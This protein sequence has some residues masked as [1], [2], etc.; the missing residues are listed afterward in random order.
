MLN[1]LGLFAGIGGLELGLERSGLCTS[2]C[3]VEKDEYCQKVLAGRFPEVPIWDDVSTFDGRPWK[4][5]IDIISGGFPC[6]DISVAGRGEG[7][8]GSRSG[9]WAEFWRIIGEI[10]PIF[11]IIENVPMLT[12]RGGTRV[13]ADLASIGYNAE[14]CIISAKEMGALHIR[15]RIFIIAYPKGQNDGRNIAEPG[16]GQIQQPRIGPVKAAVADTERREIRAGLRENEPAEKRR[17]R[18]GYSSRTKGIWTAE[19]NVGRVANG[20]SSRVDRLKCLGNAVVP[21]CGEY[22]GFLALEALRSFLSP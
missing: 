2:V 6:Q 13:I 14:W 8:E 19:P 20:V 9:L 10:R 7:I 21:Q 17:R 1:G 3:F 16:E 15:K 5:R 12:V 22:I 11:A 18:L 4:G